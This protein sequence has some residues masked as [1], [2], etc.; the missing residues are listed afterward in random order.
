MYGEDFRWKEPPYEYVYDKNPFDVI[1]GT[2]AL[3]KALE[4][5][6][7]LETIEESWKEGLLTYKAARTDYLLY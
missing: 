6:D 1:S 7:S 4:R 3:R 2:D 5:G